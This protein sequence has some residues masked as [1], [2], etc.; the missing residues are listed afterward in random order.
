MGRDIYQSIGF[1]TK[2]IEKVKGDIM[3]KMVITIC[4]LMILLV[5]GA[6]GADVTQT[7][8][9]NFTGTLQKDG[10]NV[11]IGGNAVLTP[12]IIPFATSNNISLINGNYQY[13]AP[14]NTSTI[15]LPAVLTNMT[16]Y[17]RIDLFT[18]TN[19]FTIS[20]NG[21]APVILSTNPVFNVSTSGI[22]PCVFDKPYNSSNWYGWALKP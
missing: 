4:I 5:F 10:S 22:T 11:L 20:T 16:Y 17:L 14:T 9:F 1:L 2:K 8:N 3:R 19:S 12:Y 13:Y 7:N 18:D 6:R 15:Y 21:F